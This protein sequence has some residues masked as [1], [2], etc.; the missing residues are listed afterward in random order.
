[1]EEAVRPM[2]VCVHLGSNRRCLVVALG[3]DRSAV[4]VADDDRAFVCH[5]D[6]LVP[7]QHPGFDDV[8]SRTGW[9][10]ARPPGPSGPG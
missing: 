3:P 7:Y 8:L 4:C 1:M 9:C 10:G 2:D 5:V 6:D